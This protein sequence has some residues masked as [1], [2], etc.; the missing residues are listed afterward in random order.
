MNSTGAIVIA[1]SDMAGLRA[2]LDSAKPI[3]W[4][5][6]QRLTILSQTMASAEVIDGL[7][8]CVVAMNSHVDITD[9]V[10]GQTHQF[11]VVFPQDAD[12]TRNKISV[13]APLGTALLGH[14]AGTDAECPLP[15]G[16]RRFRIEQVRQ[17]A[18]SIQALARAA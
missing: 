2:L 15:R 14:R 17:A 9:L 16:V 12:P 3:R 11:Q 8:T 1:S 10:T 4:R 7:P 6:R 13:L 5:Q 18:K